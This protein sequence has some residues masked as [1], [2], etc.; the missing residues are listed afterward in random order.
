[1][2]KTRG[3]GLDLPAFCVIPFGDE[4]AAGCLSPHKIKDTG[5]GP[6]PFSLEG[7]RTSA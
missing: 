4:G 7:N 2:A 5:T 6:G 3:Q 1:M